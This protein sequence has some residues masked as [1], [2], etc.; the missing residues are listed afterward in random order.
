VEAARSAREHNASSTKHP[1]IFT[2]DDLPGQYL[3]PS[4]T[5]SPQDSSS[6]KEAEA[7]KPASAG[8]DNPDAEQLKADL[9]AAQE[10]Q[11]QVRRE[12]SYNPAA[13]SGGDVDMQNFKP[14][15]SGLSLGATPRMETQPPSPAQVAEVSLDEKIASLTSALRMACDSPKDAQIQT[16]LDQAEQQLNLLQRQFDLDQ[17]TYYS[18]TNYA[19]DTAG[20]ANLDAEQQQIQDLQSEIDRL[21]AELAA[22]NANPSAT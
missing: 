15:S 3:A 4:T 2:N 17:T 13:I 7:S 21:K 5:K 9:Q 22:S 6:T 10:E 12:L 11:D 14:G 8:C 18:Q 1:K 19:T 16:K 20:K